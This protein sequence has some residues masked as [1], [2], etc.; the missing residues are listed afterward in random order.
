MF[1]HLLLLEQTVVRGLCGARQ[2]ALSN[3][4]HYLMLWIIPYRAYNVQT[5]ASLN[6]RSQS[7]MRANRGNVVFCPAV[8]QELH[9]NTAHI[10]NIN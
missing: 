2:F 1:H 5:T 9:R 10:N 3:P 8:Q 6:G 4:L 7:H